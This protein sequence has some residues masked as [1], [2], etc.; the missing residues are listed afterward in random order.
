MATGNE[1]V[2]KFD[3]SGNLITS[4]GNEGEITGAPEGKGSAFGGIDGI[5]VGPGG[6]L[7]V[8]TKGGRIFEFEQNGEFILQENYH[9]GYTEQRR[10]SR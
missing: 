10:H 3:S 1:K 5:A 4:W 9:E 6:V 7:Y 2:L 8:E